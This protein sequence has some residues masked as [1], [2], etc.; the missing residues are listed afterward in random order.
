MMK[1]ESHAGPFPTSA[2][3][4]NW[5]RQQGVDTSPWGQNGAKT[6]ENLWLELQKGDCVLQKG[7]LLR[8]VAV[9]QVI[10]RR[11]SLMLVEAAQEFADG[12]VR[13][14]GIPPA[15]KM[16]PDEEVLAGMARCLQEELGIFPT[17]VTLFPNTHRQVVRDLTSPSYPGLPTRYII[18]RMDAAV[19][20]LPDTPFWRD[21]LAFGPGDPI[22]RQQWMWVP[23]REG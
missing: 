4:D 22:R 16:L 8:L 6:S 23:R 19:P 20:D 5:L 15:E 14:R 12:T 13:R 2:D 17:H 7:P 18:H 21:N 3:L 11:G 1:T 10:I 9:A